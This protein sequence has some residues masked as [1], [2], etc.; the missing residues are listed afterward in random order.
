MGSGNRLKNSVTMAIW[1]VAALGLIL[2]EVGS[3]SFQAQ[4]SVSTVEEGGE[5]PTKTIAAKSPAIKADEQRK[6]SPKI[7]LNQMVTVRH[8]KT[9][10]IDRQPVTTADY[11]AFRNEIGRPHWDCSGYD[12][13]ETWATTA[14]DIPGATFENGRF[15]VNVGYEDQ[16]ILNLSERSAQA[17]CQ[18]AGKQLLTKIEWNLATR[19]QGNWASPNEVRCT[20]TPLE[21]WP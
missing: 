1:I 10:Y 14:N 15:E 13:L 18:W 4:P 3:G 7:D 11:V 20:Y 19:G 21:S 16:P 9:Y 17:Y 6:A 5:S 12:C 8:Y 2:P